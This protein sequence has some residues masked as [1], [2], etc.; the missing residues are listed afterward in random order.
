MFHCVE[1]GEIIFKDK[2]AYSKAKQLI[3]FGFDGDNNPEYV[4]INAKMSEF[5]AAMGLSVL[6]DIDMVMAQRKSLVSQYTKN[7]SSVAQ[8]SF[9]QWHDQSECV[10]AYMPILLEN[11]QQVLT[12]IQRLHSH[13]IQTRRYFYPSLSQIEIYGKNGVTPISDNI[14]KKILCLP[15]YTN[16]AICDVDVIC[17]HV[18]AVLTL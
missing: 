4:G 12:M 9:Q 11:E 1:V 13:G 5:H 3:N 18:K 7:L 2:V 16:L 14:A 6:D 8:V 17:D 10:G 15:L